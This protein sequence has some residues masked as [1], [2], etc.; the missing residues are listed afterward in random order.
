MIHE[1]ESGVEDQGMDWK[2]YLASIKKSP[3]E[4]KMEF[5]PQAVRRIKTAIL[6]K[7]YAKQQDIRPSEDELDAEIDKILDGV[8]PDDAETRERVSSPDYRE[9]VEIQLR[10]RKT[11]EWL[12][13][14]CVSLGPVAL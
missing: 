9:Y 14:Q 12:K 1:L 13:S 4:L 6:I 7:S 10:N 5:L 3:D 11:I 8:R 2:E